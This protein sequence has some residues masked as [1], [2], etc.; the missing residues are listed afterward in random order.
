MKWFRDEEKEMNKRKQG[1]GSGQTNNVDDSF[2]LCSSPFLNL[3]AWICC[4]FVSVLEKMD[5]HQSFIERGHETKQTGSW[6]ETE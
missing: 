3:N 5:I 6:I 2:V 4:S 1:I